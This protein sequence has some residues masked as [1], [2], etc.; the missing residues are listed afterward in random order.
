MIELES[1]SIT[2]AIF[3]SLAVLLM[4]ASSSTGDGEGGSSSGSSGG[5]IAQ[6]GHLLTG[7][8]EIVYK[9]SVAT[10]LLSHF[11]YLEKI[12]LRT[13]IGTGNRRFIPFNAHHLS[14][15]SHC[16]AGM[17]VSQVLT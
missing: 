7:H 2:F 15:A 12:I 13:R 6:L 4:S 9:P 8:V 10:I 17:A 3:G 1:C 14:P 11:V 5:S 16:T